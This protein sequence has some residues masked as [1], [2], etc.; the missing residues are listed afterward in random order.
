MEEI[1]S[2][3]DAWE[4]DLVESNRKVC[5]VIAVRYDDGLKVLRVVKSN[6]SFCFV[7]VREI[8]K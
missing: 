7:R 4:G 5:R 8:R 6:P 3:E 1:K 2:F